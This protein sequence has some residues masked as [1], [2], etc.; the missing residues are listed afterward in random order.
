MK[1]RRGQRESCDAGA[2]T[3]VKQDGSAGLREADYLLGDGL[4]EAVA[5]GL[6]AR[7]AASFVERSWMALGHPAGRSSW[8]RGSARCA[9]ARRR[10]G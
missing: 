6:R 10:P 1:S 5:F 9:A 4:F 7:V 2:V 3:V 8:R